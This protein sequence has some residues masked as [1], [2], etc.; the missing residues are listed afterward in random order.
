MPIAKLLLQD[1]QHDGKQYVLRFQ[2]GAG[3]SRETRFSKGAHGYRG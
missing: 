3:K 1:F 2:E